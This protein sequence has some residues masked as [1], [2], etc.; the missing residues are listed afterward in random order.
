METVLITVADSTGCAGPGLDTIHFY[1]W[2]FVLTLPR[3]GGAA[4]LVPWGRESKLWIRLNVRHYLKQPCLLNSTHLYIYRGWK[5]F[6]QSATIWS[7]A[8]DT[9]SKHYPRLSRNTVE[10]NLNIWLSLFYLHLWLVSHVF[11][12]WWTAA[13]KIVKTSG[14]VWT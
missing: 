9:H 12:C 3:L 11:T 13:R 4:T 7:L 14:L 6:K 10:I 8:F 5:M 1:M 2:V